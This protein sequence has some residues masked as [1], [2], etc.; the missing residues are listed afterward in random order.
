MVYLAHAFGRIKAKENFMTLAT[1]TDIQIAIESLPRAEYQNL[2][3][4]FS[5]VAWEK[6]DK[7][8][9]ADSNSGKLDFL[10]EEA[11]NEKRQIGKILSY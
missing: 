1:V 8:I 11:L 7:Q 6:W 5:E 3:Q 10:I 9:E 2:W 4:W